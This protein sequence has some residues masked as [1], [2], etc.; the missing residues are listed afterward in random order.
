MERP[1]PA[2]AH[3]RQLFV[4]P[5]GVGFEDGDTGEVEKADELARLIAG[6]VL[7]GGKKVAAELRPRQELD[8]VR[9]IQIGTP[10]RSVA[11]KFDPS[12]AASITGCPGE[13]LVPLTTCVETDSGTEP[14]VREAP[15]P[16]A[17]GPRR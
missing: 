7:M 17:T 6:G 11:T 9:V 5:R 16:P 14:D 3:R 1:D 8:I 2:L 4:D 10:S 13:P 15:G 12:E